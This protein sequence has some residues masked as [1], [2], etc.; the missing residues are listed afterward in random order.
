[1]LDEWCKIDA[2]RCGEGIAVAAV[3]LLIVGVRMALATV[4]FGRSCGDDLQFL[5]LPRGLCERFDKHPDNQYDYPY[6]DCQLWK[7]HDFWEVRP[8]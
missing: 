5:A 1:M 8:A 4:H 3:I 7:H 2:N 6:K